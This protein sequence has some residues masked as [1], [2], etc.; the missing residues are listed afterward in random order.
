MLNGTD[1]TIRQTFNFEKAIIFNNNDI[2]LK[3]FV[4]AKFH[5]CTVCCADVMC[6]VLH[7]SRNVD[8]HNPCGFTKKDILTYM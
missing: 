5:T 3:K 1:V 4:L 8:S 7:T 6:L 2:N